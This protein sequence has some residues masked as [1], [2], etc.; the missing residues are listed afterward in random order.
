MLR[1]K[2]FTGLR[3]AQAADQRQESGFAYGSPV[4]TFD[5]EFVLRVKVF[6]GMIPPDDFDAGRISDRL[7]Y[8]F[9]R[10]GVSYQRVSEELGIGKDLLRNYLNLNY[11]ESSM[12]VEIL[13]KLADYFG[14]EKYYFCNEYH[15]FI[16]TVNI[17]DF[18]RKTKQKYHMTRKEFAGYL[19]VTF[20]AYRTYESGK[21]RLPRNV[22]ERLKENITDGPLT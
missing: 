22:F 17:G 1:H 9:R 18:L 5:G 14:E 13:L 8:A 12:Q 21:N 15:K 3:L 6:R 20:S 19:G 10:K 16:D 7:R 4:E 11:C 2:N